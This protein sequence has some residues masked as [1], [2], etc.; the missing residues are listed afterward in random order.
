M[1]WHEISDMT[2]IESLSSTQVSARMEV[3]LRK[4]FSTYAPALAKKYHDDKGLKEP[5]KYMFKISIYP[6][7]TGHQLI[8]DGE[9][10]IECDIFYVRKKHLLFKDEKLLLFKLWFAQ[11]WQ[12]P[13]QLVRVDSFEA[14]LPHQNIDDDI[15]FLTVN[16][17][18]SEVRVPIVGI[19]ANLRAELQNSGFV[20]N[21]I[22][23]FRMKVDPIVR[24]MMAKDMQLIQKT[25]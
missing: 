2:K 12:K 17:L 8:R 13:W 6:S 23:E 24:P 16:H 20:P 4:Y 7:L 5:Y 1:S 11:V 19:N 18:L 9:Y 25:G 3:L 21:A 15:A 14:R 22:Q 10:G